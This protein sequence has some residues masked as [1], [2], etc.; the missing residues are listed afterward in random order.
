MRGT[1]ILFI[2][3]L[4]F[5][6]LIGYAQQ[7]ISISLNEMLEKVESN[8]HTVKLSEQ[9]YKVAKADYNQTNS[10]LLP[11]ISISHSGISTNNPLM[12]FGSK[13]N[14]EILT[15]ADFN[16]SLLNNP[17]AIQN[18]TTKIEVQQPIFNAD[19]IF[20]R[21]AA[22]AKMNAFELQTARTID[23][24]KLEVT[25]AYM[26]LQVAYKAVEVL[27]KAK[28]AALENKKIA[29]NSFKQGYLQKADILSVDVHVIEVENQLL[30]TK[31]NVKNASDYLLFLVGETNEATLKPT[32]DLEAELNLNV[33]NQQLSENRADIEAMVKST[34]AYTNMHKANKM[35]YLP[36]LN[37]FGSYELY[38][39]KIFNGNA[40]G[41]LVGAQLSW[42]VFEGYKRIGKT[43]KSK[44]ELDKAEITLD[45]Y[46][47]KSQLEFN[48]AKRQL[49][50]AE[51]SMNLTNLALEQ[52]KE[53]LRIRTNRYK[54]GLEKTSD[55]LI[56]ETKYLQKQL[57]YLQTVF[58][59]NFT[60][61][62]VNFL[63]N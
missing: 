50:D 52:S 29:E 35:S 10:I 58:N 22:K 5:N 31:S 43:Q 4:L 30:T 25:K 2:S 13:L 8:N 23:A 62:Y 61:A 56:S 41:Y 26:Q 54:Q 49:K 14:Q 3:L 57:E 20:M 15:Q 37:A 9:D 16:P 33:Y 53:A 47:N 55:L 21:K 18:F 17:D 7:E 19:G 45:Q 60:K 1:S 6:I 40:N 38:D 51:N 24:I 34:E 27:E 28:E 11:N 48:K 36:S 42:S 59:Y 46:K 63:T 32:T 39:D 12:A 44:A